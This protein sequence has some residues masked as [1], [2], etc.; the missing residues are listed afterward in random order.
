[1]LA[2]FGGSL[3][4]TPLSFAGALFLSAMALFLSLSV[5]TIPDERMDRAMGAIWPMAVARNDGD[6]RRPRYAFGP[7]VM[8]FEG[9]VDYLTGR[10]TSPFSRNLVLTDTDL[11]P[12]TLT[13]TTSM[14]LRKR[15]LRYG[16]FDRTVMHHADLSGVLATG[17]SFREVNLSSA[18]L[19]L[20]DIQGADFWHAQLAGAI[21]RGANLRGLLFNEAELGNADLRNAALDGVDL[22]QANIGSARFEG[23]SMQGA[24]FTGAHNLFKDQ[25]SDEQRASAKF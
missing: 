22:R 2:G 1:M 16:V 24:D 13:K 6:I 8:L 12:E 10:L 25:L 18:K 3:A 15:D 19:E 9:Q 4:T 11:V 7:T 17:A 23:A 14:N 21:L 20:A 5:A